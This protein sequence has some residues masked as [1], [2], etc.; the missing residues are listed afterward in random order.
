ML[1]EGTVERLRAPIVEKEIAAQE[2]QDRRTQ[3]SEDAKSLKDAIRLEQLRAIPRQQRSAPEQREFMSLYQK[4][5]RREEKQLH[6]TGVAESALQKCATAEEFQRLNRATVEGKKLHAWMELSARV[7]D[8]LRW[9]RT[10]HE[11]DPNEP[12][13]VE[14]TEGLA[15][16]EQFIRDAGGFIKDAYTYRSEYLNDFK[17]GWALWLP[18]NRVDPVWGRVTAYFKD[19]NRLLALTQENEPTRVRALYGI[20]IGIPEFHFLEWKKSLNG[21]TQ[22]AKESNMKVKA[23]RT[24]LPKSETVRTARAQKGAAVAAAKKQNSDAD[25]NLTVITNR[26]ISNPPQGS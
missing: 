21:S 20:R 22:R 4:Q 1:D 19:P 15:D 5:R 25:G 13:Y 11:Q 12:D 3:K 18:E 17:P 2:A 14:F 26:R 6:Q 23:P 24:K 9:M 7:E 16:L 8:Q 10:W